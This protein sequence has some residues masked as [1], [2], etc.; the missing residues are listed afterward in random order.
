MWIVRAQAHADL[1]CSLPCAHG[2]VW[3]SS[4]SKCSPSH[5]FLD[6]RAE[7][8]VLAGTVM[9]LLDV[10]CS[11]IVDCDVLPALRFRFCGAVIEIESLTVL[12]SLWCA[13]SCAH[14]DALIGVPR[15]L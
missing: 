3:R 12:R 5:A 8:A 11:D 6:V 7:R 9:S 2:D 15:L 13:H 4:R 14:H 10:L 1:M